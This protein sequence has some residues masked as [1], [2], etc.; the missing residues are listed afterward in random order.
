MSDVNIINIPLKGYLVKFI[1][2]KCGEIINYKYNAYF[3]FLIAS[4]LEK[5]A[6]NYR[7]TR[8]KDFIVFRIPFEKVN[9]GKT[10][11]S[12]ER[13]KTLERLIELKFREELESLIINYAVFHQFKLTVAI[14]LA[15][16]YYELPEDYLKYESVKKQ[17][18]RVKATMIPEKVK[19]K[20]EN[21]EQLG[22]KIFEN[23]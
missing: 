22:R 8:A 5:P 19:E 12:P 16:V 7:P 14:K 18:Q 4:F 9:Q 21:L 11:I 15:L 1:H 20:N 23:A 6:K 10:T 17:M 13:L 3:P 2:H